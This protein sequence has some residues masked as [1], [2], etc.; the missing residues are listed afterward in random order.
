MASSIRNASGELCI[1]MMLYG[2]METTH[3]MDDTISSHG[4]PHCPSAES[5]TFDLAGQGLHTIENT[6]RDAFSKPFQLSE[7][8]RMTFI[9]GA[10]KLGRQKYDE[11]AAKAV[12]STLRECG[13]EE[14]RGASAVMECA[15]SFKLQHD[16]GKNL[17]TVVVFPKVVVNSDLSNDMAGMKLGGSAAP[18]IDEKSPEYKLA[19]SSMTVFQRNIASACPSWNQKKGCVKALEG[20]LDILK[21]LDAKLMQGTPLTEAED[22]LYNSVSMKSLEEKLNFVRDLMHKHVDDGRI[23]VD[24]RRSLLDQV[25][26]RLQTLK[27]EI[28]E[29]EKEGKKKRVENITAARAKVEERKSKLEKTSTVGPHP[30]KH[31][32]DINKLRREMLP[33]LEIED[34]AKG[35]LLTLKESQLVSRKDE[36]VDEIQALEVT[37]SGW[38]SYCYTCSGS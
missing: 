10:G 1:M 28:D 15:G 31:E 30:L 34:A 9:V 27:D 26:D 4:I 21:G 16:T 22:E 18:L 13:F 8:I 38:S 23:T 12:T 35:R 36:I 6:I 37:L 33:L 5:E 17:K 20:L 25:N 14:D 29:A 2:Y 7:M 3:P 19:H 11:G 24:E 32:A